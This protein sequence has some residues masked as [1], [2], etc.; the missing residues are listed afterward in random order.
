M[1]RGPPSGF[2]IPPQFFIAPPLALQTPPDTGHPA[3]SRVLFPLTRGPSE[4]LYVHL[5]PRSWVRVPLPSL[6]V[7]HIYST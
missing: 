2:V 4:S 7:G 5:F 6:S 1:T 3:P